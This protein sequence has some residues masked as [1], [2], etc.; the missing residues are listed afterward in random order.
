VF[1]VT[2]S[3]SKCK[4]IVHKDRNDCKFAKGQERGLRH[5]W[6]A[7]K[8]EM[9]REV[10]LKDDGWDFEHKLIM[11]CQDK[12]YCFEERQT[13]N[14]GHSKRTVSRYYTFIVVAVNE[15]TNEV[16][17]FYSDGEGHAMDRG[18]FFD[19]MDECTQNSCSVCSKKEDGPFAASLYSCKNCNKPSH[20]TC[21]PPA[22]RLQLKE[23]RTGTYTCIDC[24][25]SL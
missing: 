11:H 25:P 1:S 22:V 7:V 12:G 2:Q 4:I 21:L 24:S 8:V 18:I 13:V 17:Q 16:Y 20:D 9:T 3:Y 5:N 15:G 10:L 14:V 23:D 19:W 6:T